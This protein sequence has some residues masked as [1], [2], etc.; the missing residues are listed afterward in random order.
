MLAPVPAVADCRSRHCNSR[1]GAAAAVLMSSQDSGSGQTVAAVES[2]AVL[3]V[4]AFGAVAAGGCGAA[5]AAGDA[6]RIEG[7]HIDCTDNAV[8]SR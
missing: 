7:G 6:A 2:A 5:V 8:D 3:A 4:A 1:I